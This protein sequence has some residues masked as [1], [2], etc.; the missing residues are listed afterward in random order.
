MPGPFFQSSGG[1]G[2][3]VLPVTFSPIPSPTSSGAAMPSAGGTGADSCGCGGGAP[4]GGIAMPP[5]GTTANPNTQPPAAVGASAGISS[6]QPPN[7]AGWLGFLNGPRV[8]NGWPSGGFNNPPAVATR[9]GSSAGRSGQST[10]NFLPQSG[11]GIR[12]QRAQT[13]AGVSLTHLL[14]VGLVIYG[15]VKIFE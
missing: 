14:L 15:A 3:S 2:V 11:Q 7:P 12:A 6:P 10:G 4:Y 1:G 13:F 5:L 8:G 9:S